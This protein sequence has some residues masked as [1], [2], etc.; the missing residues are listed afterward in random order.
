MLPH[1]RCANCDHKVGCNEVQACVLTR[2]EIVQSC[3]VGVT[4]VVKTSWDGLVVGT[5]GVIT[6]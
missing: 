2:R 3:K 6:R 5:K 1:L 4:V